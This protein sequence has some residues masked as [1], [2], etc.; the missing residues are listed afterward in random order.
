MNIGR[1]QI[2]AAQ[3]A[4]RNRNL[5]ERARQSDEAAFRRH[6]QQAAMNDTDVQQPPM[7]PL[8]AVDGEEV[9]PEDGGEDETFMSAQD[10]AINSPY[11]AT[12]S[13]DG[14]GNRNDGTDYGFDTYGSEGDY[15][16][17]NYP[18]QDRIMHFLSGNN[19]GRLTRQ[20][21]EIAVAIYALTVVMSEQT[22]N[23]AAR[24]EKVLQ[25]YKNTLNA[26]DDNA[27]EPG[28]KEKMLDKLY[29]AQH[30]ITGARLYA[31]ALEWRSDIRNSY[32]PLLPR[33]LSTLASGT[34][35]RDAY[36]K[37]ILRRYKEA[38]VS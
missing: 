17:E 27:F 10:R 26:F 1:S 7:P 33:E 11:N 2:Q 21:V 28:M 9:H 5:T 12:N 16:A 19:I 36:N 3:R 14:D 22:T 15:A 29:N 20:P 18:I 34:G 32:M 30:S 13:D 23:A 24:N 31:K 37:F 35:L 8:P 25:V 38:N 4:A 6:L